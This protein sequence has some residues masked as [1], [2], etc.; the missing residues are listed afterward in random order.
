M[1]WHR[2]LSP[3]LAATYLVSAAREAGPV[4]AALLLMPLG[5][6]VWVICDPEPWADFTGNLGLTPI[7]RRSPVGMV[8][9]LAWMFLLVPAAGWILSLASPPA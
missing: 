8:R 3:L 4:A 9:A 5:L 6:L 2:L 1:S 7:R